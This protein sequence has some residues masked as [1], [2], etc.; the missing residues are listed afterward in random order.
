M[1]GGS[2]QLAAFGAEDIVLSGDSEITFWK[3]VYR[4]HT[5]FAI[6][7]VPVPF[8]GVLDF[9]R[10]VTTIIPRSAD[11]LHRMYIQVTL[12]DLTHCTVMPTGAGNVVYTD[13]I[14]HALI[15]TVELEINGTRIDKHPGE[16]LSIWSELTQTEERRRGYNMMIGKF[17][18]YNPADTTG[19]YAFATSKTLYIPLQFY[20]NRHNGMAL[21]LV[22]LQYSEVRVNVEF[23]NLMSCIRSTN[24]S[25]T[26]LTINGAPPSLGVGMLYCDMI[27]LDGVERRR[28]SEIKH[29]YLIESVQTLGDQNVLSTAS[30]ANIPTYFTHPC[31]EI[32]WAFAS[33]TN[34][35]VDSYLGNQWFNWTPQLFAT[36]Q[37][38]FNGNARFQARF[39]DYFR[40]VQPYEHHTRVPTRYVS[41]YCFALH[42]EQYQ[43]SG[44]ANFSK[45]DSATMAFTF[46]QP[47][48]NGAIK[49]FATNY[50]V[51]RIANGSAVLT[52]TG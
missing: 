47:M 19:T 45:L 3:S 31:K 9:G 8:N 51:L 10:R 18:N 46:N 5:S 28:F 1:S 11:L 25:V 26:S 33:A 17:D 49:I 13:E 14:G 35:L 36:V 40:L 23:R 20:C 22:A 41:C 43:P 12:P 4:R 24:A 39:G 6:E 7:A 30:A 29:E 38:L 32:I 48:V 21:P 44:E 15:S 42:P 50:N 16:W 52:Y 37:Y 34:T 2:I 27:Y